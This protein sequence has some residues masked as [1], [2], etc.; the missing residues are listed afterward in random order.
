MADIYSSGGYPLG[1]NTQFNDLISSTLNM[2][3]DKL[4]STV[5][6]SDVLMYE[7]KKNQLKVNGGPYIEVPVEYAKNQNVAFISEWESLNKNPNETI[8]KVL[9]Q[10][11]IIAGTVS[12]SS[13]EETINNGG[14]QA[15]LNLWDTRLKNTLSSMED[16]MAIALIDTTPTAKAPWSLHEIVDSS[17]PSRGNYGGQSRTG[18]DFWQAKESSVGSFAANGISTISTYIRAAASGMGK[19]EP[20]LLLLSSTDFG[21][22]ENAVEN[23][24]RYTDTSTADVKFEN[25]KFGNVKVVWSKYAAAG[26]AFLINTKE[27]QMAIYTM[28]NFA[29]TPVMWDNDK[30][31]NTCTIYTVYNMV[32]GAPSR[33]VKLTGITA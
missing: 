21:Y 4:K 15:I 30:L 23:K 25:L 5:F 14:Q 29:K 13:L 24:I 17:D 19:D 32:T 28:G 11:K 27:L 31:A 10:P 8:T 6:Y 26:T 16:S 22:M 12:M 1:G 20:N 7:L 9:F 3:L 33:H 2:T 18:N